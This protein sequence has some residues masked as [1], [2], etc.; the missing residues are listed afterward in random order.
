MRGSEELKMKKKDEVRGCEE[1]S[2]GRGARS[3]S[4]RTG[5]GASRRR[6]Y[7][8]SPANPERIVVR[9]SWFARRWSLSSLS[10]MEEDAPPKVSKFMIAFLIF[11]VAGSVVVPIFMKI[12]TGPVF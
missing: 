6:I 11:V 7:C 1:R 3:E 12:G 2:A 5:E 8:Q 4:V 10:Q 9:S